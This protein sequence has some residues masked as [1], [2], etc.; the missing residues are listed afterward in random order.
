V[1]A[2]RIDE[3]LVYSDEALSRALAVGAPTVISFASAGAAML[4]GD[5]NPTRATELAK[6]AMEHALRN[7]HGMNLMTSL[8]AMGRL[9]QGARDP[10]W[11]FRYRE[12]LEQTYDAGDTRLVFTLL[13]SY[14][15]SLLAV[16]RFETAAVLHG[17]YGA[18]IIARTP[19]ARARTQ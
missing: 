5:R 13:D 2:Q 11:A 4:E 10:Q 9:A 16:D 7:D 12:L 1:V 19:F 15:L 6:L 3:A 8:N 14:V 17:F 18:R